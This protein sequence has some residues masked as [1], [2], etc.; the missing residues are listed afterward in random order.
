MAGISTTG[1]ETAK[2]ASVPFGDYD[3]NIQ[4]YLL[5]DW[6]DWIQQSKGV[7]AGEG[8][9]VAEGNPGSINRKTSPTGGEGPIVPSTLLT[10]RPRRSEFYRV[11]KRRL[12]HGKPERQAGLSLGS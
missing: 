8:S 3:Y 7:W 10:G 6:S 2:D 12:K 5:I 4:K 11:I 1:I 9:G